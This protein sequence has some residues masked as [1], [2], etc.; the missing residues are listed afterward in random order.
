MRPRSSIDCPRDIRLP[1]AGTALQPSRTSRTRL[2]ASLFSLLSLTA[3]GFE[4]HRGKIKP[5]NV[6]LSR[7]GKAKL[8]DFGL[9]RTYA[10]SISPT[11]T[12]GP[13]V[14]GGRLFPTPSP[15]VHGGRSFFQVPLQPKA[16]ERRRSK[17]HAGR[18]EGRNHTKESLNHYAPPE[19]T[20]GPANGLANGPANGPANGVAN[21]LAEMSH[22]STAARTADKAS[23]GTAEG[24][25]DKASTGTAEGVATLLSSHQLSQSTLSTKLTSKAGR[26]RHGAAEAQLPYELSQSILHKMSLSTDVGTVPYMAPEAN[27]SQGYDLKV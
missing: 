10:S 11:P 23:T 22:Q 15:S 12:P 2:H 17:E 6:L 21:G 9:S 7:S 3:P 25:A 27:G 8:T 18:F 4:P 24:V 19:L 1:H 20:L 14:H 26:E 16:R 13:S 5:S